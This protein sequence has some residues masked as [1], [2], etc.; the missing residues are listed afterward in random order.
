MT[1]NPI[2]VEPGDLLSRASQQMQAGGFRRLPVVSEATLVGI[3]TDR[4]LREHRDHLDHIRINAVMTERPLTATPQMT[5]EEA[6]GIML[7]HQIGGLPVIHDGRLVGII[8]AS[9]VMRAFL[10]VMGAA[11]GGSTRIDFIIEGEEHG[12]IEASRIVAREGAEVLGVGTYRRK[13]DESPVCYLR[14]A[15]ANSARI[16]KALSASGFHVLGVHTIG[17][18]PKK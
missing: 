3:V 11:N 6:A 18:K 1:E 17:A 13:F 16:A 7:A 15:S 14:L 2:T 9:D 12:F 8:T 5:L 10:D 4:D